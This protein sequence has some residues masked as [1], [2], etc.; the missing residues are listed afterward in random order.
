MKHA[1]SI[2]SLFF[3]CNTINAFTPCYHFT[4]NTNQEVE[5][6]I[7]VA[8]STS[9]GLKPFVSGGIGLKTI[10][11]PKE[12]DFIEIL[13]STP[14]I[15][16]DTIIAHGEDYLII[17]SREVKFANGTIDTTQNL[18]A[19]GGFNENSTDSYDGTENPPNISIRVEKGG[20]VTTTTE[21]N[22]N[23]DTSN[24]S[25]NDL[26]DT[27][28]NITFSEHETT[29]TFSI[30]EKSSTT[31]DSSVFATAAIGVEM[32]TNDLALGLQ[33]K[34]LTDIDASSDNQIAIE[35]FTQMNAGSIAYHL[36]TGYNLD[37]EKLVFTLGLGSCPN[38]S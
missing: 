31:S 21:V 13:V 20:K 36:S 29:T 33:V 22:S 8:T 2:L 3:I 35:A 15:P 34:A 5:G 4:F 25:V 24:H 16:G 12:A 38:I 6:S 7:K 27:T 11:L 9:S 32:N 19:N 14:Q 30:P 1:S 17:D 26:L 37:T 23:A 18:L 10:A 28:N